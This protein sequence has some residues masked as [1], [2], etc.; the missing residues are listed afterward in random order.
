[1]FLLRHLPN[2]TVH[3]SRLLLLNNTA[4]VLTKFCKYVQGIQ[5]KI[6]IQKGQEK[7]VHIQKIY[8]FQLTYIFCLKKNMSGIKTLHT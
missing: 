8:I 4:N 1:M 5:K 7:I 2:P 3:H 6:Q